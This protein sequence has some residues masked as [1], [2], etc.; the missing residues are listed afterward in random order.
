MKISQTPRR[1]PRTIEWTLLLG[2][3]ALLLV[4]LGLQ[5][6]VRAASTPN[7]T[8]RTYHVE[9]VA[10]FQQLGLPLP[11]SSQVFRNGLL[12]LPGVDYTVVQG[13]TFVMKAALSL[14]DQITVV[15]WGVAGPASSVETN[16]ACAATA[17]SLV[18]LNSEQGLCGGNGTGSE[19]YTYWPTSTP[20]PVANH[21]VFWGDSRFPGKQIESGI[22]LTTVLDDPGVDTNVPTEKAVRAAIASAIASLPS[23]GV[24]PAGPQGPQGIPGAASTVAG[25]QGI[26]GIPGP[27]GVQGVPGNGTG[28]G[29]PPWTGLG[30]YL[31]T[32]G[33]TAAWGNIT[34]GGSGAL[35]CV[36]IA[37]V[38]DVV[39]AIVPLKTAANAWLGANDFSASPFLRVVSG[40]GAPQTGCAVTLNVG[41][42]Y[43]RNDAQAPNAS[44]YVCSQIGAALYG[45][46][47]VP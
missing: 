9:N 34:T 14:G 27:Q 21:F 29:L 5:S 4:S 20:P 10:V 25:P 11:A 31:T 2:V 45:W 6:T 47:L 32:N 23:S 37:G 46:E 28:S 40:A 15:T 30:G 26:Q 17:G 16:D 43:M 19:F 18:Y 1:P 8:Y 3:G 36:S 13:V 42:V 44:L 22:A 39:T 35:D 24:G 12:I 33:L 38:C 7:P 41:S